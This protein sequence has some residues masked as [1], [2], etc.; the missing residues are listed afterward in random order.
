MYKMRLKSLVEDDILYLW[1]WK[2][3]IL[4]MKIEQAPNEKE[5]RE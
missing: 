5:T 1:D 4:K 3:I 2:N